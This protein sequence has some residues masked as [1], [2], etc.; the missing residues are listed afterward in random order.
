MKYQMKEFQN[1]IQTEAEIDYLNE[2]Y[3]QID[4]KKFELKNK[5]GKKM[6]FTHLIHSR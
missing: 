6:V 5:P 4:K 2:V 3:G 1:G